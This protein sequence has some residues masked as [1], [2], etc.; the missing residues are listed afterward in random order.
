MLALRDHILNKASK[1]LALLETQQTNKNKGLAL[2][3]AFC[4]QKYE[5]LS[6]SHLPIAHLCCTESVS[7]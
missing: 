1:D 2:H 3:A 5:S 4:N 7:E 6:A